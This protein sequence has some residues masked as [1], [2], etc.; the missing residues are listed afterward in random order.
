MCRIKVSFRF[1]PALITVSSS[2]NRVRARH[3]P[4][5]WSYTSTWHFIPSTSISTSQIR[6]FSP[7]AFPLSF[8]GRSP[9]RGF[10]KPVPLR[11]C[12]CK[13]RFTGGYGRLLI[14][15]AGYCREA[16]KGF[17]KA[18]SANKIGIM[19]ILPLAPYSLPDGFFLLSFPANHPSEASGR[20]SKRGT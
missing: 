15:T 20:Q 14:L 13:I 3:R 19:A 1:S 6:D 8:E 17:V 7:M 16:D 10:T 2:L 12:P 4:L 11:S 9:G 5:P 18:R